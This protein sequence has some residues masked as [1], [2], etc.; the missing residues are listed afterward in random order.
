MTATVIQNGGWRVLPNDLQSKKYINLDEETC[1]YIGAIESVIENYKDLCE[2]IKIVE[3]ERLV[4][5][6]N[7]NKTSSRTNACIDFKVY[8]LTGDDFR[9]NKFR[10]VDMA[11]SERIEKT[12]R[13]SGPGWKNG[14]LNMTAVA[15][16]YN[17]MT[18]TMAVNQMIKNKFCPVGGKPLDHNKVDWKASELMRTSLPCFNGMSFVC[19]IC[20]VSQHVDNGGETKNATEFAQECHKVKVKVVRVK[21]HKFEKILKECSSKMEKIKKDIEKLTEN[22]K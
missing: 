6:T 12:G 15:N 18:F 19:V 11:G 4:D 17:L 20:C 10:F 3:K 5:A 1:N 21:T 13:D 14:M 2:F 9:E 22:Q 7:S 16:N 8:R